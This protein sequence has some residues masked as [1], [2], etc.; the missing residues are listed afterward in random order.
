MEIR[1]AVLADMPAVAEIYGDEAWHRTATFDTEPKP[2]EAW[3]QLLAVGQPF[4]VAT[5]GNSVIGFAYATWFSD[6]PAYARTRET[7]IYIRADAHGR[8]VGRGLYSNLLQALNADGV[9]TV[10]AKVSLP[11]DGSDSFHR[12]MGFELVGTMRE[13]GWK[14]EQLLDVAVYQRM[15]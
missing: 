1:S 9:H 12:R 11:S 2:L 13:V 15:L 6:R 7:T 4:L 5:E 14:F 10:I 3:E 8:G